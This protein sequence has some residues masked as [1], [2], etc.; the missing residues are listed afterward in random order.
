MFLH[1]V[2][3]ELHANVPQSILAGANEVIERPCWSLML[4]G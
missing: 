2:S 4:I 1:A 3:T